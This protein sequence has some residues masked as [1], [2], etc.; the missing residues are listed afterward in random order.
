MVKAG[1]LYHGGH[2]IMG[3]NIGNT[4][5]S[6]DA[7]QNIRPNKAKSG[8]KIDGAIATINGLAVAMTDEHKQSAYESGREV[9]I[10]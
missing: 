4:I 5:V 1:E 2:E 3:W 8:K 6:P 10:V 7:N 9:L